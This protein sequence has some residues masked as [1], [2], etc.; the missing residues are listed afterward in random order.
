MKL[1][2][3]LCALCSVLF[4]GE[5]VQAQDTTRIPLDPAVRFGRLENGLTYYVRANRYPEHRAELRLVVNAGSVLEDDDQRGLAHFVEH[6]A[7][8]G[9]RRFAKQAL[10]DFIEGLGM[11]FGAHL[12]ASTSFDETVY[13]LQIPTDSAGVFPR[14]LDILEDWARDI[15]FETEEIDR[16]RGVVVEEW[17]LGLG[18]ESRMFD[19]QLPVL[20]AGSRYAV[21]LPIGD[22]RTLETAP[23]DALVRFYRDWYRPDLMAVVA[24]G[25]FDADSVTAMIRAQ[26]AALPRRDNPRPRP[27]PPAPVADTTVVAVATDPEAT[28]SR[29]TVAWRL[30]ERD[31]GTIAAFRAMLVSQLHDLM[32]NQ[33]LDELTRRENPPFIGAGTGRGRF[34]RPVLFAS[35]G[36]AV[37][38]GEL[39]RGL[40][41]AAIEAERVRRHGFTTTELERGKEDFLRAYERAFAEREKTPSSALI[42]EYASHFLERVPA[43]GIA[44]EY[45]FAR[46]MLPGIT[47][48]EVNDAGREANG[49]RG[50]ILLVNAPE[51]SGLVPPDSRALV[52]L[53]EGVARKDIAPYADVL[54]DAPLVPAPPAPG[55]VGEERRN[56]VLGTTEWTLGNGVRVLLKPTDFKA[57]EV[58]LS[59]W[60]PGGSSLAPD[61]DWLSDAFAA[62]LVGL[63]GLG[64][65]DA[66]ALGKKLAGK[67]AQVEANIS[68]THEGL[69]GSAS[70]RDLETLFQLTWLRITAPRADTTA[71]RAFVANV[72]SSIANRGADPD[73]VFSDTLTVTMTSH[74]PRTRPITP[75]RVDSL[76]LGRAYAFYRDRFA[77]ASDFTFAIVGAFQ[78]DSIRPLVERWLGGLPATRR[79]ESWR[80]PGIVAPRGV[81]ERVVRKGVEPRSRTQIV[82]TGPAP[83]SKANRAVIRGLA[84]VLELRLRELLREALGGT[85]DVSVSGTAARIPREEYSFNIGFSS[86][87]ERADELVRTV[88]AAIDTLRTAGPSERDLVKVVEAEA[89]SRETALRQNGYWLGPMADVAHTGDPP[90][91]VVDPRGD[92]ALLT[93]HA[94]RD[95]A[96]RVLDP[97]NYIRVTLLPESKP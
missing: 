90:E 63:G 15:S 7:F 22:K 55:A 6:M 91:P 76:D 5:A 94:L 62:P 49:A 96:R 45:E 41:A 67:V 9:T 65:F 28:G 88:F 97:A 72:R 26:F 85:Y 92:G 75:A 68:M 52:A 82:F 48:A 66:T 58:L 47:I 17:R 13:Q 4:G 93:R 12:N 23:R 19:K 83:Y 18:A 84:S 35:L 34:V 16:E 78:L 2:P 42:G 79:V 36:V 53:L 74:H 71:F 40:E 1:F 86:A 3:V 64:A 37:P 70:P 14:A 61:R 10:I 50:R 95:A 81:V 38:D 51:K 59:A 32:L 31:P 80:D 73:A 24:V 44:R 20:L 60:S 11:R 89:R 69:S 56:V 46:A 8:N 39:K 25:D 77:D 27:E 21:R 29:A 43:P 87:P 30:P 33:R 57:D 54:A